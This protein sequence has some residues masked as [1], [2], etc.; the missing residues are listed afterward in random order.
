MVERGSR[1]ACTPAPE[2]ASLSLK[3]SILEGPGVNGP[4]GPLNNDIRSYSKL[5]TSTQIFSVIVPA[6]F[7][8]TAHFVALKF[9]A[10][11][12]IVCEDFLICIMAK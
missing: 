8:P 5:S 2:T 3:H 4:W 7:Q 12:A 10:L 6:V 9:W 1:K 11:V